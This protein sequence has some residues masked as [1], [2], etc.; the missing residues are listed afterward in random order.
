MDVDTLAELLGLRVS[1]APVRTPER[2]V[3]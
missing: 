1:G 3:A 2:A